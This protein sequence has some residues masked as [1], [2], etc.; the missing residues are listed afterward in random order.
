MERF[1]AVEL[2]TA[3]LESMEKFVHYFIV[4]ACLALVCGQIVLT[5]ATARRMFTYVDILEGQQILSEQHRAARVPLEIKEKP[6]SA[7]V[8][9]DNLSNTRALILA[10]DK[11]LPSDQVMISV[12][13]K[14]ATALI[15]GEAVLNVKDGDIITIDGLDGGRSLRFIVNIPHGDIEMPSSGSVIEYKGHRISIGPVRF[16]H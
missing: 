1:R 3:I 8:G 16:K 6:A 12:N 4:V 15:N 14:N 10:L 7:I 9:S 13:D 2:V 5:Q 11:P